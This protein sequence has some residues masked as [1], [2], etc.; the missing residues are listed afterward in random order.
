ME[1]RTHRSKIARS[2]LSAWRTALVC[3]LAIVA[4]ST[5]AQ[6]KPPFE[7]VLVD[8]QSEKR[9]GFPVD[10]KVVADSIKVLKDAGVTGV[11]L[12]FFYDQPAKNPES[13]AALAEAISSTKTLLQARMDD[14]EF[15]ENPLPARFVLNNIKGA[16]KNDLSGNSGWLPLPTFAKGA[17]DIGF[18]DI[19]DGDD[20]P[21]VVK[22]RDQDVNSLT[23]AAL[24]LALGETAEVISG[25][26]VKIGSKSLTLS[27][28]NQVALRLESD[29]SVDRNVDRNSDRSNERNGERGSERLD[30]VSFA[31]L[32]DGKV[33]A[34]RLRGKVVVI[35]Y[36]GV[37]MELV[38]TNV[39]PMKADRHFF[40]GLLDVWRQL[41]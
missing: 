24:E 15:G 1:P 38:Q 30:Y 33:D 26:K 10:R 5:H 25:S 12:K 39:G 17:H 27:E 40:L 23:L 32:V 3:T 22:Y 37:K 13:D 34:A 16:S 36:D 29:K 2:R 41:K 11:V 8:A 31:D 7:L 21:M 9:F 18:V 4:T 28:D 19:K 35:G 14:A 20:V 6:S